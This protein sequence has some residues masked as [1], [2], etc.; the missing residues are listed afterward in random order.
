MHYS[1]AIGHASLTRPSWLRVCR[2][3]GLV[4]LYVMRKHG[5]SWRD[6]HEWV[7]GRRDIN[8]HRGLER[9]LNNIAYSLP[10][11]FVGLGAGPE[12]R[13]SA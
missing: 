9:T 1:G 12:G 4:V 2:S 3:A 13:R 7:T 5:W 11:F 6:A 8:I 10:T